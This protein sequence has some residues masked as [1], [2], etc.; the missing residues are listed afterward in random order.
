MKKSKAA[1]ETEPQPGTSKEVY[2]EEEENILV[3]LTQEKTPEATPALPC[4][5]VDLMDSF[6][7]TFDFEA[8]QENIE[9]LL[10][11]L[12]SPNKKTPE[13]TSSGKKNNDE[14]KSLQK[15]AEKNNDENKSPQKTAEKNNDENK[16]S[17]K[18]I[19][20]NAA[21]EKEKPENKQEGI[22]KNIKEVE[23][24]QKNKEKTGEK[25]HKS[26]LELYKKDLVAPALKRKHSADDTKIPQKPKP[27]QKRKRHYSLDDVVQLVQDD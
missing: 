11:S 26:L 24:K 21:Q 8:P 13:K 20:N 10:E 6:D 4:L 2:A 1:G 22:S 15:T 23:P 19:G 9:I 27:V 17:Q 18:D 12:N 14:K 25:S 3:D 16:S 5:P 7:D